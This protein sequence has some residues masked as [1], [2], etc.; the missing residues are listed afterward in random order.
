MSTRATAPRQRGAPD[1]LAPAEAGQ[2]SP[3]AGRTRAWL[4]TVCCVAQFMVILDLSIVNVALPSI[5]ASLGF[6]AIGLQWVVDAYSIIFAG[7]LMLGGRLADTFGQRRSLAAALL[8]FGLASLA[9]GLAAGQT[10][11]ITARAVQGLSAALMAAASLAAITSSFAPGPARH[12]AI[13]LWG[14]MNG[15]GGAAGGLFGGIITQELGWRWV[16]LINPPI[17]VAAALVTWYVVTDR[18]TKSRSGFDL[19]GAATLTAGLL[20]T[21]YGIVNASSYGWTAAI[22]LGPVLAGLALT[23]LFPVIEA[24]A[25]DPLVPLKAVT[26]QLRS[27]NLIV[28]LFSAALFPMWYVSSL[29]L[30]Q[31][32]GLSPLQAGLAFFPMALVIMLTAQRAGKLVGRFG[33]RAVLAS[34]LVLLASGMALLARIGDSGSAIGFVLLPGLLVAIGIGLSIVP[35]TIA[36]TQAAGHQ[37]AGLA[38]GL[39]NTSRQVGGALGIALLVS[40]ATSYTSHLIGSNTQVSEALTQGFRIAYLI[41]AGLAVLAAIA[42]VVLLRGQGPA[43]RRL[44]ARLTMPAVAVLVVAVFVTVDFTAAGA[45]G[46]PIGTYTTKNSYS[47]VSAPSLHP[48]KITASMPSDS[49]QLEPG[50]ILLAN[51]FNVTSPPIQGQSGPLILSNSLQPVWFQPV[52]TSDVASDLA[53][54][55]YQGKPVLTWWEGTVTATGATETGKYVVVNQHYQPIATLTGANG[56]VLTLHSMVISGDDAWVT[57]NKNT[58]MN[59]SNYGGSVDGAIVDSAVQEYDLKTGAL[60]RTWDARDHIPVSDSYAIPQTNGF[61]WDAY[62]VNSISLAPHGDLLVSM[63]DTWAAYLVNPVTGKIIWTLGGKQSSFRLPADARFEW[64]HDVTIQGSKVT[65]FDDNCCQI[66]GAGTYL[67]PNGPSRAMTLSISPAARTAS[68]LTQYT[69]D[70]ESAAYMGSAELLPDGGVFVGFGEL[71]YFA[72]YSRSGKRLLDGVFPGP[73]MSY[74]AVQVQR[75]VGRPLTSPSA[76]ARRSDGTTR[77]YASWNGAT[78]VRSWRVLSGQAAGALHPV[79]AASK[80]GF[81][82]AI[83]VPSGSRVFQVQ[84]LN[85]RGKVIGTSKPF[86]TS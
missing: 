82:T 51:F 52:P 26:G 38:S 42:T 81:Q 16:L 85:A 29:Y 70:G 24:R 11:L 49:G 44:T 72:E 14:A 61:P 12:R 33:V 39:V 57:A 77:V 76:V 84:A 20:V 67:A 41:A 23:G 6:T 69:H 59:L 54:Q 53:E 60:I 64:Q 7:F 46:P 5:Q 37:Q 73:D 18:P 36:A 75:W 15:A 86:T 22:A 10:M 71:P 28:A 4:L 66:S 32:L 62:H 43:G 74:R 3:T 13:G 68:L 9:G 35:S 83:G 47:Y 19:A 63:R 40:I 56:W 65:L 80:S 27:A 25:S 34:G 31:V 48:P 58:P 30:Q 79:A 21:A 1:P 2:E 55:T 78:Q 8:L 50:Y 17:G 45:P